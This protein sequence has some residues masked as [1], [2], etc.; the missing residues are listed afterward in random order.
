MKN[1]IENALLNSYTY[2]EYRQLVSQLISEGKSTGHN[3]TVDLLHYS[4]LNE[5][6]LKRLDKTLVV[7]EEN[8]T[9]IEN[10]DKKYTWLVISEGWCGDAAQLLPI[11]NKVAEAS[12]NIDLKIVLRDDNEVLMNQF[13]TNGGK[14]IPKL[15]VLDAETNEIIADW[16]PRPEPARKLIADYKA[17]NGVVDEPVKIELQ[18]WYLQ[19]KGLTTQNELLAL[20]EK[21]SKE[22]QTVLD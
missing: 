15:I 16:G 13:L 3:Q 1:I 5:T 2:S 11:M 22:S 17:A 14:A 9:K 6:R 18:K 7:S 21:Y 10:L 4:E 8:R 12:E 20:L 19:D